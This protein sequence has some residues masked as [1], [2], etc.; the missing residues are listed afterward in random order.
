MTA[1]GLLIV[2]SGPS[3]TGK[4]T[5]CKALFQRRP[6]MFFSVSATTR[7][8]RVGEVDGKDYLFLDRAKFDE[9]V[10]HDDFLEYAEVYD[11]KY[12]TPKEPVLAAMTAGKDVLLEIDI[13][14]ALKVK[15]KMPEAVYI[16]I[17]PP[18]MKALR[19]RIIGRGT[20]PLEIIDKRMGK[21]LGELQCLPEYNYVVENDVLEDAVNKV[22]S[23]IVAEHCRSTWFN[24]AVNPQVEDQLVILK[25]DLEN[26]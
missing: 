19:H 15:K 8:P 24:P 22:E 12:G 11:N 20:D 1:P 17:V 14:G 23:I 7:E 25:K 13:Q 3:G 5:I 21:A 4:G 9:M 26:K 18:S 16:F 6:D 2:I 10:A